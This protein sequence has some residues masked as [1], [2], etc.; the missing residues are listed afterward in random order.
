M[1]EKFFDVTVRFTG[2]V[3]VRV[4]ASEA[5]EAQKIAHEFVESTTYIDAWDSERDGAAYLFGDSPV[6]SAFGTEVFMGLEPEDYETT[7]VK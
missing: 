4:K 7:E 2:E 6:V 3:I 5:S 1:D